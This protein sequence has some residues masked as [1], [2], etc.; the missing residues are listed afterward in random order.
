MDIE[1]PPLC[2]E[3]TAL[4]FPA[5]LELEREWIDCTGDADRAPRLGDSVN[6]DKNP[7]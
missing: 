3:D 4:L 1:T 2:G 5:S 7:G 6:W